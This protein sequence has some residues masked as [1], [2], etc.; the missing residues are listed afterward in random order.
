MS[1][2]RTRD[3]RMRIGPALLAS[4]TSSSLAVARRRA[5]SRRGLSPAPPAA[6]AGARRRARA[7]PKIDD[8]DTHQVLRAKTKKSGASDLV[9]AASA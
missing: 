2:S 3:V 7:G 6:P 9:L 1:V 5:S 8:V 4:Y